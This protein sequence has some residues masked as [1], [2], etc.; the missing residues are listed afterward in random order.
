M[1]YLQLNMYAITLSVCRG[2]RSSNSSIEL[3]LSRSLRFSSA[4]ATLSV[5]TG[6]PNNESATNRRHTKVNIAENVPKEEQTIHD[7]VEL[8]K[9]FAWARFDESVDLVVNTG[10]DPRKPNQN[11]KGMAKLPSGRGKKVRVCVI[12][13][14]DDAEAAKQAGADVVGAD[15]IIQLIQQG[16]VNFN[17]VIATPEMMAQV[18]KIGK[19]SWSKPFKLWFINNKRYISIWIYRFWALVD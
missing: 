4:T 8:V 12:A 7:A 10:L 14:S 15:E 17:T 6:T 1:R 13:Q 18:G 5:P 3:A 19:V 9:Q 2:L 16:D 11:I